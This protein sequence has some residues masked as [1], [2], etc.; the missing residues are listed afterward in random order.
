MA[1]DQ[2]LIKQTD[3]SCCCSCAGYPTRA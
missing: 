3:W 1:V 2:V